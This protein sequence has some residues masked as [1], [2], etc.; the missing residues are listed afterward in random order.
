MT[1]PRERYT[2]SVSKFLFSAQSE[3]V[4]KYREMHST[5]HFLYTFRSEQSKVAPWEGS[6]QIREYTYIHNFFFTVFDAS[7]RRIMT[8]GSLQGDT[9][10]VAAVVVMEWL[11]K[12]ILFL[13]LVW[14]QRSLKRRFVSI[15]VRLAL[16]RYLHALLSA[17][18]CSIYITYLYLEF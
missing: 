18:R 12:R 8:F 15:S 11:H 6:Q 9:M 13:Y 3:Q 16:L 17:C 1:S 5:K 7:V 10:I 2:D 4:G 14:I